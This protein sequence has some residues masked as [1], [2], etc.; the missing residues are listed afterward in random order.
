TLQAG[1]TA[2]AHISPKCL[3]VAGETA[4][5]KVYDGSTS[6]TLT[7]GSLD[8]L[9][10][11]DTVTLT[12]GGTFASANV[13]TGISVAANDALSGA[14]ASNYSVVQPTGLAADITAVPVV[15]GSSPN[16]VDSV[17]YQSAV[18]TVVSGQQGGPATGA[19]APPS[20]SDIGPG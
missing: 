1:E 19:P 10:A 18:S 4:L 14:S 20:G 9:V 16:P 2:A 8:G 6:A 17:R 11:G 15:H 7:G 3:T 5:N 12:E 13:G